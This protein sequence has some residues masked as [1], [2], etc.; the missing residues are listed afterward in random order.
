M[1]H[2][3]YSWYTHGELIETQYINNTK[4]AHMTR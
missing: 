2:N 3:K 1:E 4:G